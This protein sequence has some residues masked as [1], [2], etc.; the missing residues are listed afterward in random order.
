MGTASAAERDDCVVRAPFRGFGVMDDD[1]RGHAQGQFLQRSSGVMLGY[2]GLSMGE[3]VRMTGEVAT[4]V[5]DVT[6]ALMA[7]LRAYGGSALA[8][9]HDDGADETVSLGRKLLQKIFGRQADSEPLPDVLV[10]VIDNP[11][12]GDYLGALRATIREILG[13]E[14]QRLAEVREILK[15][16]GT[17][18]IAGTQ[19]ATADHGGIAQNNAAGGNVF[20]PIVNADTAATSP[21]AT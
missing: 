13:N 7:A 3:G 17:T 21:P 11:D 14:A 9:I 4:L 1:E 18:V 8:K 16:A 15:E 5:K 10:K 19:T 6:P 2:Q 12:D 20:A